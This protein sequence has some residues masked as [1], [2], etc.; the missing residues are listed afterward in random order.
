M[1]LSHTLWNK[2]SKNQMVDVSFLMQTHDGFGGLIKSG[3]PDL[4]FRLQA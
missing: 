4:A 3:G 2:N 1:D